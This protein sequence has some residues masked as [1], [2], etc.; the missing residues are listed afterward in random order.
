VDAH[1]RNIF[2]KLGITSRAQLV[3]LR[4]GEPGEG[5]PDVE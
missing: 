1:L 4:L 3:G 5:L 2:R